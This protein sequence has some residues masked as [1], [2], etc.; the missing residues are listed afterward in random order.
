MYNAHLANSC[1]VKILYGGL[2]Y[3]G[4][5]IEQSCMEGHNIPRIIC[6]FVQHKNHP[7]IFA[8]QY[9]FELEHIQLPLYTLTRPSK[10]EI[11]HRRH[12]EHK[13]LQMATWND[14]NK[15]IEKNNQTKLIGSIILGGSSSL[16]FL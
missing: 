2:Y 16:C 15:W 4:C 7:N 1:P 14:L 10:M 5:K 3:A 11:Y 8:I 12:Q 13:R 6:P 9:S